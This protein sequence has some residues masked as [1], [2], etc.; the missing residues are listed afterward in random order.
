MDVDYSS[1]V[2]IRGFV[3]YNKVDEPVLSGKG[4]YLSQYAVVN[5]KINTEQEDFEYSIMDAPGLNFAG[6]LNT[7]Q[8]TNSKTQN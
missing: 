7:E 5:V 8:E 3:A 6:A 2:L 4:M 1:T